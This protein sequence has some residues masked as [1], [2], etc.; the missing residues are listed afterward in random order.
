MTIPFGVFRYFMKWLLSYLLVRWKRSSQ[1]ETYLDCIC[2][3]RSLCYCRKLAFVQLRLASSLIF[4]KLYELVRCVA[5]RK[6]LTSQE[7]L[8]ALA[9][10]N[11]TKSFDKFQHEVCTLQKVKCLFS[12][13][14][15][16]KAFWIN[17][18]NMLATHALI[19]K[20]IEGSNPFLSFFSRKEF[21]SE[22]IYIINGENFS[23]EDIE[24]GILRS[25]YSMTTPYSL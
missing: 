15:N 16:K 9:R 13:E 11:G 23:L 18:Y 19:M 24:N 22:S 25:V 6:N 7:S 3:R 20:A 12:S 17:V 21:F 14:N 1:L 4:R 2:R 10:I 5:P 8:V